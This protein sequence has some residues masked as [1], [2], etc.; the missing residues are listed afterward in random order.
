VLVDRYVVRDR[1]LQAE[2]QGELGTAPLRR[3]SLSRGSYLLRL[4]APGR[5]E[6]RYPVL[7]ER[8]EHWDGRPP[9]G[10]DA[11]PIQLL[12]EDALGEDDCYVPAGWFWAG[13]DPE[14][15]DTLPWARIWVDSFVI[16]RHPVTNAQY[17]GFLNHLLEQDR[18]QDALAACPRAQLGVAD[19]DH[20]QLAFG[21]AP[22]GRFVL[23][24]YAGRPRWQPDWPVVLV[25][26]FSACAYAD[27]VASESGLPWRLP[28]ELER[29][30]A[31]RGV[32]GRKCPWGDHLD[33]RFCHVAESQ[34][35]NL[36]RAAVNAPSYDLSP[37]GVTG[38]AG[39]SRDWCLDV[40]SREGSSIVDRRNV[41][42]TAPDNSGL[43]LVVRGG[44]WSSA[45]EFSRSAA[46]F[47]ARPE[48]IRS[49]TG[50]RLTRS[51]TRS[52]TP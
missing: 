40:W 46:R 43:P 29:E 24:S 33:A 42:P 15:T 18:E 37:Y 36:S 8:G 21:R 30:K 19:T 17:L 45:T 13:G 1:R 39:N 2:P 38:L 32:D 47:A 23:D 50:I 35:S 7:I 34:E 3:V 26:W 28:S 52:V 49:S 44:A 11:E 20:D 4:Q 14:A 51:V 6:V 41:V 27:W 22:D 5:A 31:A 10:S 25:D 9:G 16:K 48:L 12:A